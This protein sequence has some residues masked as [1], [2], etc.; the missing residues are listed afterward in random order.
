MVCGRFN[1]IINSPYKKYSIHVTSRHVVIKLG[2][3]GQGEFKIPMYS[4]NCVCRYKCTNTFYNKL[5][6]HKKIT[7]IAVH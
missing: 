1:C 2:M 3:N 4:C 6:S 7:D 5:L